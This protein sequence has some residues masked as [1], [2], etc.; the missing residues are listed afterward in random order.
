[1]VAAGSVA[2]S[3]FQACLMEIVFSVQLFHIMMFM[4][5]WAVEIIE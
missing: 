4:N 2:T 1:M 3:Q 5:L